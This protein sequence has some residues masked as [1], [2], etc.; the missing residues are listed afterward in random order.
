[1][2]L[3][4]KLLFLFALLFVANCERITVS[5][6]DHHPSKNINFE[7][8]SDGGRTVK[9]LVKS[10]LTAPD[11]VNK[12]PKLV[13]L[14][15]DNPENRAAMIA[16]PLLF[17]FFFS[18]DYV[19]MTNIP[20]TLDIDFKE[21]F[22]NRDFIYSIGNWD[23]I[24][25][26]PI[27]NKGFDNETL[28]GYVDQKWKDTSGSPRNFHFCL[29]MNAVFQATPYLTFTFNG[30]DDV[31]VFIDNKLVM[32][33][34]GTHPLDNATL[35]LDSLNLV[36]GET[37]PF[38]LYF[39]ERRDCVTLDKPLSNKCI[40]SRKCP[41][42]NATDITIGPNGNLASKCLYTYLDDDLSPDNCVKGVCNSTT[43]EYVYNPLSKCDL[44]NKCEMTECVGNEFANCSI[45]DY[46]TQDEQCKCPGE[47]QCLGRG[48]LEHESPT[49][50]INS[51]T[52][53]ALK[54]RSEKTKARQHQQKIAKI[55]AGIQKGPNRV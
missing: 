51:T 26:F 13:S 48:T 5:I 4:F 45:C 27:D 7:P 44:S 8:S 31:W 38:D 41:L 15:P 6:Y 28:V 32:D 3:T 35:N 20:M 42:G 21:R 11:G 47:P 14:S 16:S 2:R 34:G 24:D 19:N 29:S 50:N 30:D 54:L 23:P 25:F 18:P 49:T 12:I 43:G 17:P 1:M 9:G 36:R 40:T 46:K 39:C 55:V 53:I 52:D 33:L 10:T 22:E 37:Y